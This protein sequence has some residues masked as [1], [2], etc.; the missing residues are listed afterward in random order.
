M[1]KLILA[2]I[3]TLI[4]AFAFAAAVAVNGIS[5]GSLKSL[6][7]TGTGDYAVTTDGTCGA[8]SPPVEPPSS[9]CPSGV[10]CI[11]RPWPI[12]P[13][14][15]VALEGTSVLAI[16]VKAGASGSGKLV[17]AYTSGS[18]GNR[19]V[20]ISSK[21]GDFAPSAPCLK[22]GTQSTTTYWGIG[23]ANQSQCLMAPNQTYWVN[24]R[25]PYCASR[26][27]FILRGY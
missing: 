10:R 1:K 24:I 25:H 14:E 8:V 11:D 27:E 18:S 9:A 2:S 21:P 3:L 22:S 6:T 17:T 13:Q 15:T 7:L 16:K 4:S 5:C 19:Q 23:A 12:V 20:A 26:C